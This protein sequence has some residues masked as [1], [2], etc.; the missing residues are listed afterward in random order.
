M[1]RIDGALVCVFWK[2]AISVV[3][4]GAY[5]TIS[6]GGPKEV[7][8]GLCESPKHTLTGFVLETLSATGFTLALALTHPA[9]ALLAWRW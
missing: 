6:S 1:D 8:R 3:T 2:M 5:V 7:W 9:R 4:I